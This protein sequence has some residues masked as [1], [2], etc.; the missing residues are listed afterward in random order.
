MLKN[1]KSSIPLVVYRNIAN[2]MSRANEASD[3]VLEEN[4]RL[5]IP[6]PFS[7]QGR[8]YNLMPDGR[9]V[10]RARGRIKRKI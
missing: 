10:C 5:H 3:R 6:T 8:I 4:K 2:V 7:L 9:I 1:K